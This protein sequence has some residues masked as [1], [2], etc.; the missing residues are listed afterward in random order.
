MTEISKPYIIGHLSWSARARFTTGL[1]ISLAL[2]GSIGMNVLRP[3]DPFGAISLLLVESKTMLMLRLIGMLIACGILSTIIVSARLPFFGVF[4]ASVGIAWPIIKTAGM[5]YL[6]VRLQVGKEFENSQIL[7]AYLAFETILW[8]IVLFILLAATLIIENWLNK[9]SEDEKSSQ[10]QIT[11]KAIFAKENIF[12]GIIST[13]ST[14][15]FGTILIAI[16]AASQSKGQIVF[17][18]FTGM[19]LAAM[20]SEQI[21]PTNHPIWQVLAVPMVA[22]I[23]YGYTWINPDR[24]PG[25]EAVLH[26]A[27]NNLARVLPIEYIFIGTAGAVMGVWYSY[28]LR[29][30]KDYG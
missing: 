26:I 6:M 13:I 1:A 12:N 15:I 7:W 24:P 16:L 17:A 25:F 2:F 10:Y 14:A 30:S 11:I 27:P 23:A 19:L 8:S 3:W 21:S 18:T 20:I 22:L 29:H 4:S 5:D 9:N 28:R